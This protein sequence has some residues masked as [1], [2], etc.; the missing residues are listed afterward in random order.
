MTLNKMT[1]NNIKHDREQKI[2]ITTKTDVTSDSSSSDDDGDVNNENDA[3][4]PDEDV[5]L[6]SEE[7]GTA[8][9]LISIAAIKNLLT[10]RGTDR[11]FTV[12]NRREPDYDYHHAKTAGP[13][14]KQVKQNSNV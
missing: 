3:K 11:A 5:K 12:F 1:M 10:I 6:E 9:S 8:T 14:H 2:V 7:R 4:Y 13:K